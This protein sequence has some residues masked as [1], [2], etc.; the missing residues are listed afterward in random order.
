M[1]PES[2]ASEKFQTSLLTCTMP[3]QVEMLQDGHLVVA[4][5]F[6]EQSVSQRTAMIT[7]VNNSI[8]YD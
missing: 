6:L 4:S 2:I 3:S 5:E 7:A 1:S 8:V